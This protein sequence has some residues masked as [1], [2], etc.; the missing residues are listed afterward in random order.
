[1]I[2]NAL[3]LPRLRQR[4]AG[5]PRPAARA[6]IRGGQLAAGIAAAATLLLAAAQPALAARPAP[7]GQAVSTAST[8]TRPAAGGQ[9]APA[10]VPARP[11]DS[12]GAPGCAADVRILDTWN[13]TPARL[14]GVTVRNLATVE[15]TTWTVGWTLAAGERVLAW[16]NATV[17]ASGSTVTATNLPASGGLAPGASATF[18]V[19]V[20]GTGPAPAMSC[21]SDVTL[22]PEGDTV[23]VTADDDRS[24]VTVRTG[25]ILL[26]LLGRDFV[27]PSVSGK[28]LAPLSVS[29]GYPTGRPLE[30]A[31]T[32]VAP[33][34]ADVRTQ[35]D[36]DCFHTAPP[37]A[38]PTL[39]WSLHVVVVP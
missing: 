27:P 38:L 28:A 14:L 23:T 15:S 17:V 18:A 9:P 21:R 1:M 3:N 26:V 25:Q 20:S 2:L 34:E 33:G 8:A 7:G 36:Y 31:Y 24:T 32:A 13:P 39:L 35:T 11:A 22:P 29:G 16:W 37:C 6:A 12:G 10:G 4:G 5:A 19:R 30:A